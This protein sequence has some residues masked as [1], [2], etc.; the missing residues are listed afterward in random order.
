MARKSY[1]KVTKKLNLDL[2]EVD[3]SRRV[4]VKNEIGEF[5]IEE[6]LRRVS[7]GKSPLKGTPRWKSLNRQYAKDEKG[8]D[9]TPNLE[10]DGDLLDAFEFKRTRDGIEVGVFKASET[11]KA[12]GHNHLLKG[13]KH[14]LPRR[15]FIPDENE[16]FY[17]KITDG[18]K[19]II[20]EHKRPDPRIRDQVSSEDVTRITLDDILSDAVLTE[21]LGDVFDEG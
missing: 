1:P 10:L 8:G 9:T 15:R 7:E 14:S 2:S 3:P 16:Q 19:D 13:Y 12:D 11:G 5:V 18:V 6:V 4:E 21:I 20:K 17:R